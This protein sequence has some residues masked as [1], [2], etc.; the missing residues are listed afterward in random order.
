MIRKWATALLLLPVLGAFEP[1]QAQ[2]PIRDDKRAY[3]STAKDRAYI[4]ARCAALY[5]EMAQFTR[6]A[7][8]ALADTKA[9]EAMEF[10]KRVAPPSESV[11]LQWSSEYGAQLARQENPSTSS[12]GKDYE[13]CAGVLALI[14]KG[15]KMSGYSR[16][17]LKYLMGG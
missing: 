7:N 10:L 11:F 14:R 16:D 1:A 3:S 15:D 2:D 8:S 12:L 6:E 4:A 9:S 13:A 5:S 17:E